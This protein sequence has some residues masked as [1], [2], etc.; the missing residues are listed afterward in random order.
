MKKLCLLLAVLFAPAAGAAYKC[1]DEKGNT[2]VGDTP[3]AGCANVVM[4][5]VS[6][7]GQLLRRI[8]PTPTAEQVRQRQEEA[9]RK[10][11]A[12]KLVAEQKR[13][14][15][16]LLNTFSAEREFDVVRDRQIE[17]I[18]SRIVT[19][20]ERIKAIDKREKEL[21]DE[22]E[23]YKAGKSNRAAR[24]A[25][26]R[27]APANLTYELQRIREERDNLARNI[28]SSSREIEQLRAK[29]DVDKRRW[30]ALK[31]GKSDETAA[32]SRAARRTY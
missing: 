6:R 5:E 9:D 4:Y 24:D 15:L 21:D 18:R 1:V 30:V 19:T 7:S 11:E 8:D 28:A 16:A 27:E 31:S 13:K 22:M 10:R 26:V 14:D 17:P 23:F 29:F 2:H 32:D 20:Q 12:D 3:P 25:K